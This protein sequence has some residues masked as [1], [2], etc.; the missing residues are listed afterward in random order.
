M[1]NENKLDISRRQI[2]FARYWEKNPLTGLGYTEAYRC[3]AGVLTI[4]YGHTL[5]VH[6]GQKI[7]EQMARYMLKEDLVNARRIALELLTREVTE[8]ELEAVT[9]WIFNCKEDSIR[10]RAHNT[11][12]QIN[13]GNQIDAIDMMMSWYHCGE[14]ISYGLYRRCY[15]RALLW[16]ADRDVPI[17]DQQ[18]YDMIRSLS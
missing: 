11:W 5:Y 17:L 6:E 7:D 1:P 3:P 4:G 16:F 2:E 10:N 9:D 8:G 13:V 14:T 18:L 12:R 15:A